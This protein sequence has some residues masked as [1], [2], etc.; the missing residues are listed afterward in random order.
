MSSSRQARCSILV[1]PRRPPEIRR[2]TRC[3]RS[4]RESEYSLCWRRPEEDVLATRRGAWDRVRAIQPA[5]QRFPDRHRQRRDELRS[6][7]RH[8]R[9]S[10]VRAGCHGAQPARVDLLA[11]LLNARARH[12]P[13]WPWMAP[14]P[15]AVDRSD[16]GIASCFGSRRTS[17]LPTSSCQPTNS[18]RSSRPRPRSRSWVAATRTHSNGRP[19]SRQARRPGETRPSWGHRLWVAQIARSIRRH[20]DVRVPRPRPRWTGVRLSPDV[21]RLQRNVMPFW[22]VG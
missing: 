2:R 1:F 6:D 11:R 14:L 5:R 21:G 17:V 12:P 15:E 19:T 7:Q 20:F 3:N 4:R 18:P 10:S 22:R 13:K 16:P 9:Y 8:P